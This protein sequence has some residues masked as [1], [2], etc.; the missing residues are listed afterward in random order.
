MT[1]VYA[2]EIEQRE[3]HQLPGR[4]AVES[5]TYYIRASNARKAI[6]KAIHFARREFTFRSKP[7][8]IKSVVETVEDLRE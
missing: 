1:K 5:E 8:F 4:I 2:I 6:D 7:L 3:R